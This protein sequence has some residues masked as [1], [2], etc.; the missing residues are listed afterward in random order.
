MKNKTTVAVLMLA[1][2][3]LP[4]TAGAI[5]KSL[6]KRVQFL[7]SIQKVEWYKIEG[8]NIIIGWKGIPKN[9]YGLNYRAA[10]DAS[11]STLYEVQVWSVRYP[12]KDWSPGDGG[13][14]CITTAKRGRIGKSSCKK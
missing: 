6:V 10:L 3:L 2:W 4:V 14:V 13:Q 7:D 9:F 11:K 5:Q 12:Q 8:R 1:L